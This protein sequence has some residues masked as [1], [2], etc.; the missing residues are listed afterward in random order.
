MRIITI[1]EKKHSEKVIFKVSFVCEK[2][3]TNKNATHKK[4]VVYTYALLEKWS[5][6]FTD[7]L[8]KKKIESGSYPKP[9][10][11]PKGGTHWG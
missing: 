5:V 4:C 1:I 10:F 6:T 7:H 9:T 11:Q 2:N 8:K 3:F